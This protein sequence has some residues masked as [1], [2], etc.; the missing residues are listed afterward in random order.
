[1]LDATVIGGRD[2]YLESAAG[3]LVRDEAAAGRLRIAVPEVVA[4][5]AEANH[6]RAVQSARERLVAAHDALMRLPEARGGDQR[7]WRLSYREDFERVLRGAG[8]EILPVPDTPHTRLLERSAARRRPFDDGGHGYRSALVW[9]TVLAL[10]Q[11]ARAPVVLVSSDHA[12]FSRTRQVAELAPE[13]AG[14]LAERGCAGRLAL[15]FG[16]SELV[17]QIPRVRELAT[18]WRLSIAQDSALR[19]ALTRRLLAVA[20]AEAGA[21]LAGDLP[22]GGARAP[23]ILSFTDARHL[24][25]EEAWVSATGS[26]LLDVS[27]TVDYALAFEIPAPGAARRHS[28]AP[29]VQRGHSAAPDVQWATVRSSSAIALAFEVIQHHSTDD[30]GEF[31]VRL[32][33][34]SDPPPNRRLEEA[35]A[36]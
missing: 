8:G 6:R 7:P 15:Y 16:L 22:G 5:E 34:W 13:L 35:A 32:V 27:L 14:E 4:I 31:G 17:A 12:A 2:R 29:D 24:L 11:R 30:P 25:V 26:S 3:R 36:S 1:V 21:L 33:G 19:E 18:R 23:R 10:L 20:H 9:D 28:A